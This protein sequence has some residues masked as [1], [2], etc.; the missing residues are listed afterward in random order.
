MKIRSFDELVDSLDHE[1]SWRKKEIITF[2]IMAKDGRK[3]SLPAIRRAGIALLYAH[4]EG[5]VKNS[6]SFYIEFISRSRSRY[7]QLKPNFVAIAIK[8]KLEKASVSS[9]FADMENV[10]K[11]F[12]E[13]LDEVCVF[14]SQAVVKT[15]SNLGADRFR[16]IISLL[17]LDYSAFATKETA[18]I[19]RLKDVR[20]KI[21]HGEWFEVD[22]S[23]L[24]VMYDEVIWMMGEFKTQIENSALQR[25]FL[26]ADAK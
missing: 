10:S 1:T 20:N 23:E 2:R 17:G 12:I 24:D 14:S 6:G 8:S 7:R 18:V 13:N 11:F 15:K 16:E 9:R 22:A 5:F 21:A 19:E 4:W 3:A 25:A 26:R